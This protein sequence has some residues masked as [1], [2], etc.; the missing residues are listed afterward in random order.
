MTERGDAPLHFATRHAGR[1]DTAQMVDVLSRWGASETIVNRI[2]EAPADVIG[3]NVEEQKRRCAEDVEHVQTLL[4]N[5][6]ADR[7]WR[8]RGYLTTCRAHHDR[9]QLKQEFSADVIPRVNG[10][11]KAA[12]AQKNVSFGPSGGSAAYVRT[13]SDWEDIVVKVLGFEEEGIVRTIV[14]YL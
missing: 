13:G 11:A 6:P 5:A 7:A 14:G 3:D 1:Q 2:G 8:R 9:L 12:R 10:R 4:A